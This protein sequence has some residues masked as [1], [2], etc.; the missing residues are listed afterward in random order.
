MPTIP[1]SISFY[2]YSVAH[3]SVCWLLPNVKTVVLLL[4]LLLTVAA[5]PK[6]DRAAAAAEAP[7]DES[8]APKTSSLFTLLASTSLSSRVA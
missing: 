7:R 2:K 1:P 8:S 4:E 5:L 3:Q 6:K